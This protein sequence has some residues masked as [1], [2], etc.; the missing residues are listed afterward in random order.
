MGG[1]IIS[2]RR[3]LA[4]QGLD[5]ELRLEHGVELWKQF[6]AFLVQASVFAAF[7]A[8]PVVGPPGLALRA[9]CFLGGLPLPLPLGLRALPFRGILSQTAFDIDYQLGL[10]SGENEENERG[11]AGDTRQAE[12]ERL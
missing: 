5:L 10:S 9:P 2:R 3:L 7:V 4:P 12:Q 6:L 11:R 1:T 8:L